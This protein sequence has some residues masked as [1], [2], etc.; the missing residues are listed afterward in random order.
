L[1]PDAAVSKMSYRGLSADT[2]SKDFI[3][4]TFL[5]ACSN[6][7][8]QHRWMS[9]DTWAELIIS[10]YQP[11]ASLHFDGKKLM[12]AINKCKWLL[13]CIEGGGNVSNHHVRLFMNSYR[14]KKGP[15]LHCFYAAP[16]GEEPKGDN[17]TAN[18]HF[19]ICTELLKK[20]N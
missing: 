19:N 1:A 10:F 18:W 2:I 11:S 16:I 15:R 17:A 14:P 5:N 12:N 4:N 7:M 8:F 9:V 6:A 3:I 20:K 13:P